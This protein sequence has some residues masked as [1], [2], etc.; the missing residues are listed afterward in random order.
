MRS[1]WKINPQNAVVARETLLRSLG[2]ISERIA[3]RR[4]LV[5]S[6]FTR[7]DLAVVALLAP[8]WRDIPALP[9]ELEELIRQMNE[10]EGMIW[11]KGIY[12]NHRTA[13]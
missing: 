4:Y 8:C 12:A 13:T 9:A 1:G 3:D 2:H 7:A 5:D 11:A 6:R 10:H